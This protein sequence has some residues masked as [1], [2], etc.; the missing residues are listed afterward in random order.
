MATMTV[1]PAC[2]ICGARSIVS[3]S[4]PVTVELRTGRYTVSGFDY[5]RCT[6]CAEEFHPAGQTDA[7]R[8][9][10]SKL[11][12]EEAGL[13]RPDEIRE[14]RMNLGLTQGD[15]ERL[16]GVGEKTV[17]RWE[18]GLFVQSKTADTLMRLLRAHPELVGETGFVAREGR[19]PYRKG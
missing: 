5:E 19:G 11:A 18:R 15:L 8:A 17:G 7:I 10:A 4:E 6:A 9:A 16:L 2:P 1:G 12:R 13:L 3:T 14:L